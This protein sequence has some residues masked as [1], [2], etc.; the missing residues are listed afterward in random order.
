MLVDIRH[1]LAH[2]EQVVNNGIRRMNEHG[3]ANIHLDLRRLAFLSL[4]RQKSCHK[5]DIR[6]FGASANTDVDTLL[7]TSQDLSRCRIL[8][9]LSRLS[10]R[11][12]NRLIRKCRLILSSHWIRIKVSSTLLVV[13]TDNL[14]RIIAIGVLRVLRLLKELLHGLYII[15]RREE[16]LLLD[17]STGTFALDLLCDI[18][19]LPNGLATDCT[20]TQ[21]GRTLLTGQAIGVLQNRI[22][23]AGILRLLERLQIGEPEVLNRQM[24][25]SRMQQ[26][27]L[28]RLDHGQNTVI[29]LAIALGIGSLC[30]PII[31]QTTTHGCIR[32]EHGASRGLKDVGIKADFSIQVGIL[33]TRVGVPV[34]SH[35]VHIRE[36]KD[37]RLLVD[38]HIPVDVEHAPPIAQI[39]S[40]LNEQRLGIDRQLI[41][42]GLSKLGILHRQLITV[43]ATASRLPVLDHL[44]VGRR[45]AEVLLLNQLLLLG[46]HATLLLG[47]NLRLQKVILELTCACFTCIVERL[48]LFGSRLLVCLACIINHL[49]CCPSCVIQWLKIGIL[50]CL[51]PHQIILHVVTDVLRARTLCIGILTIATPPVCHDHELGSW[52]DDHRRRLCG[53]NDLLQAIIGRR[54]IRTSLPLD[55]PSLLRLLTADTPR[56]GRHLQLIKTSLC[57]FPA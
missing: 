47:L 36:I 12:R 51:L 18:L 6:N 5:L 31:Q 41:A 42:T 7:Q 25:A 11:F 9:Q 28:H 3:L 57:S 22:C 50:S 15:L 4:A 56:F 27:V 54:R 2:H 23:K 1:R 38:E 32:K 21:L 14:E 29:R 30:P 46:S 52:I 53:I 34:A 16:D 49:L 24:N 20:N 26:L 17:E 39:Q 13:L 45:L 55:A 40:L 35:E 10:R 19:V 44:T 33:G 8:R 48:L 43:V 37:P